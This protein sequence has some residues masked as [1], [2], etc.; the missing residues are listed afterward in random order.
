MRILL[1]LASIAALSA[2][3]ARAPQDPEQAAA[4]ER[5]RAF[6]ICAGCHTVHAGGIH[7]YGPNLHGVFGRRAGSL[8][9]YAYSDGMRAADIVWSE[10]TLDAFLR[11][12]S[13]SVPGTR[14][15]N[16]F[17]DPERRR[18][19]IEYLQQNAR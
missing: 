17:P 14:M 18:L 9:G 19:V 13:A 7:R 12:P 6:A 16:A 10:Q 2:C 3:R 4:L 15:Y 8:A 11:S 1:L 5:E